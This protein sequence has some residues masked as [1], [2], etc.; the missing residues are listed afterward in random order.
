VKA[1]LYAR[2]LFGASAVLFGVVQLMWHNSDIWQRLRPLG[3]PFGAIVASCL[4][5]VLIVVGIAIL[6]PR[7]VRFGS[8]AVAAVFVLF[9]AACIP[10]MVALPGDW[11]QYVDF[12]EKFSIA[13]GAIALCGMTPALRLAY[14]VCVLSYAWAQVVYLKYTASLVPTWIPP[15][16]IFWTNLTTAAFALAA[17]AILINRQ[18]RTATRLLALMLALFGV[19]V[20]VPHIIAHP[21]ALS[22]WNEIASNYLMTGAAWIFSYA[23]SREYVALA[24]Q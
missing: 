3:A 22:N 7:T 5:I 13:C 14:G 16:Q 9:A 1:G 17:L 20:W 8:V 12:F 23:L 19:L 10:G 24:T 11:V 18:V 2:I 4:A 6:S 21:R 15:N